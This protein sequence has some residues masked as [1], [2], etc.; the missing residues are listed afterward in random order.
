MAYFKV[1][2]DMSG[3]RI[4]KTFVMTITDFICTTEYEAKI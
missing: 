1:A 3:R 4:A 2:F